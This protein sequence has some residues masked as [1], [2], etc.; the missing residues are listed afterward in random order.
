MFSV[1]KAETLLR[2]WLRLE[3]KGGTVLLALED[4]SP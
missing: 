1:F 4:Y 2:S 3:F